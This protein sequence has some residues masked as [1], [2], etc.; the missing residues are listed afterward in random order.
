MLFLLTDSSQKLKLQ[1]FHGTLIILFYVSPS[2]P[3][4]QGLLFFI[5]KKQKNNNHSS[6]SGWWE[7]TKSRFK[8]NTNIFSKNSTSQENITIWRQ[9]LLF[10]IKNT[11]K[12]PFFSKRLV[13]K[14]QIYFREN[15]RT[16]SKNSTTQD[17]IKISR[18]KEKC[19]TYN[20]KKTS[21]QN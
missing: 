17:N 9:N 2:S 7:Y 10:L 16:F 3:Q 18:L 5:K 12:Q 19:K 13:G 8:E 15:A 11:K 20:K 14:H 6:P 21:N 1:M 4:L